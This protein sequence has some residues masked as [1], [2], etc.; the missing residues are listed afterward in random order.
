MK[1][2]DIAMII[3]I[4]SMTALIAFLIGDQIPGLKLEEK[5]V[6]VPVAS[7]VKSDVVAPSD[8]VFN[9]DAINPTVQTVIGGS[10]AAQ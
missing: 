4:A 3:L 2:S 1:K 7:K 9:K 5:G 6:K 8:K 10:G